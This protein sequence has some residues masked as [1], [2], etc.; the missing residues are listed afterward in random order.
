MRNNTQRVRETLR[1]LRKTHKEIITASY[2]M[3]LQ[4]LRN[5]V[6]NGWF[7]YY[8]IGAGIVGV[9]LVY[10]GTGSNEHIANIGKGILIMDALYSL[11][12][13]GP[14]FR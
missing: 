8:L 1:E 14:E 12:L 10:M 4:G 6:E 3:R 13:C 5:A 2:E 11:T 7:K 9:G